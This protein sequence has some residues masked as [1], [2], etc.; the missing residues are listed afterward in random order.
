MAEL[1]TSAGVVDTAWPAM[2]T[3]ARVL[4]VD[5]DA[6]ALVDARGAIDE[7]ERCW[8]RFRADSELSEIN[9]RAGHKVVVSPATAALVRDAISWAAATDGRFDPTV[10]AAVRDAGYVRPFAEGPGPI[11]SGCPVLGCAGIEVDLELNAVR[12][13][14]EVGIDLGGIGKGAAVD[15]T[16]DLLQPRARGGLVDLGG[17]VRAWGRPPAGGGWPIAVLDLRSGDT[18]ALLWLAEGAVATSSSLG[19]RWS[20]GRRWAHHLIDP[21]TGRPADGEL[22]QVTVVAGGAAGAEVLAK[23]ALVL[24]T[25]AAAGALLE[26]HGVAGLLV[27]TSGTAV[28]V[29]GFD[30]LCHQAAR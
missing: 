23:S 20:D 15:H 17:D 30:D 1:G 7:L 24:G 6:A 4:L 9:A 10:L 25:V 29:G 11:G 27:P 28:A 12:L 14:P 5:G 2:G 13:P 8:T 18:A 22:V 21:T 16:V 26:E 19:R 3:T